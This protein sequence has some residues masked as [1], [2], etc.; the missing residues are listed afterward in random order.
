MHHEVI[1]SINKTY[2]WVGVQ[3]SHLKYSQ[4]SLHQYTQEKKQVHWHLSCIYILQKN[5]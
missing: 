3:F 5:F 2:P 1:Q 4:I